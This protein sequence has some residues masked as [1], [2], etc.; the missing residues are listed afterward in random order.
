VLVLHFAPFGVPLLAAALQRA[1]VSFPPV[2][3][4]DSWLLAKYLQSHIY[5]P[6]PAGAASPR[7]GAGA[8]AA[9]AGVPPLM[10]PGGAELVVVRPTLRY[11]ARLDALVGRFGPAWLHACPW[12]RRTDAVAAAGGSSAAAAAGGAHFDALCDARAALVVTHALS[13]AA[14]RDAGAWRAF[15]LGMSC[16]AAGAFGRA[17]HPGAAALMCLWVL[18]HAPAAQGSAVGAGATAVAADAAVG[19]EAP[20][21]GGRRRGRGRGRGRGTGPARGMAAGR[22]RAGMSRRGGSGS[23]RDGAGR[24]ARGLGGGAAG[25]TGGRRRHGARTGSAASG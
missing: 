25:G 21:P 18:E 16:P 22:N 15:A 20:A 5:P 12:Y 13:E 14:W 24:G 11:D 19:G 9:A 1:G 8:A 23:I 4:A 10:G 2:R 6:L 7:A 3:L 17:G